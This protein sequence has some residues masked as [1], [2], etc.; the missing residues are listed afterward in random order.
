MLFD[1]PQ[2][3]MVIA[4]AYADTRDGEHMAQ[5][6]RSRKKEVGRPRSIENVDIFQ[7]TTRALQRVGSHRLTLVAV[8]TEAGCTAPAISQRFGSKGALLEAY[9]EWVGRMVADRFEAARHSGRSPLAALLARYMIPIQ[10]RPE[11]FTVIFEFSRLSAEATIPVARTTF[12]AWHGETRRMLELAREA[13]ELV[14]VNLDLLADVLISALMGATF[15][16]SGP[17][18]PTLVARYQTMFEFTLAP[19]R[20]PGATGDVVARG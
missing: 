5:G 8:A 12:E 2:Y 3:V 18:D 16:A 13:D 9:L 14:E 15:Q 19:Y 20:R 6:T 1:R 7:A 10:Q 11:E 4:Q 17:D